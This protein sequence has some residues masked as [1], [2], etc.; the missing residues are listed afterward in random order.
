MQLR[1]G[2][3]IRRLT[4]SRK[5]NPAI[6]Y[7]NGGFLLE[8][9]YDTWDGYFSVGSDV[10]HCRRFAG[11]LDRFLSDDHHLVDGR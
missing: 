8:V 3:I 6:V 1:A 9:N 11:N 5:R 10:P 4:R 7:S 2:Q